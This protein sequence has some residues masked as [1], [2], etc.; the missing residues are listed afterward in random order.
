MNR[1]EV[2][3]QIYEKLNPNA[4]IDG[5]DAELQA[6]YMIN[7]A[8]A[9]PALRAS[10]LAAYLH[11]IRPLPYFTVLLGICQDGLPLLLDL[12]NY[13]TGPLLIT[14]S[15]SESMRAFLKSVLNSSRLINPP[16][17]VD[18]FIVTPNAMEL[19]INLG[20]SSPIAIQHPGDRSAHQLIM[21]LSALVEQRNTGRQ[22]GS[23]LLLV[24]EDLDVLI[25]Y[26]NHDVYSHFLWLLR[27]GPFARVWPITTLH[28]G[29]GL[30]SHLK[31]ESLF[32]TRILV[33]SAVSPSSF[34]SGIGSNLDRE[35]HQVMTGSHTFNITMP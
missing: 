33:S 3:L 6:G 34:S 1:F 28:A 2:A 8:Q 31:I 7:E 30:F 24:I 29:S 9:L 25:R 4:A 20:N 5:E 32:D 18:Y 10:P 22:R 27:E 13:Q 26:M 35:Y 21:R 14:G 16:E 19:D 12:E 23:T 11:S 15:H 17:L